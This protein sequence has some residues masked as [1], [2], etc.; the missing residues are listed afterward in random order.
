MSQYVGAEPKQYPAI[1]CSP[2]VLVEAIS[3]P[4]DPEIIK[5]MTGSDATAHRRPNP[6]NGA[7]KPPGYNPVA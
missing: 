1:H 6:A 2:E 5:A 3:K 7:P 4:I